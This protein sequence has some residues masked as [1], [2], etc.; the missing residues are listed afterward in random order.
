LRLDSPF[1][2]L[3][4]NGVKK[5]MREM[6]LIP[7]D[8]R[9]HLSTRRM[10]IGF[11][12]LYALIAVALIAGKVFQDLRISTIKQQIE[13]LEQ[14]Q[15]MI[16]DQRKMIDQ[17]RLKKS[18]VEN[19]LDFVKMIQHGGSAG[20]VFLVFDRVLQQQRNKVWLQAWQYTAAN[21]DV[22]RKD[23]QHANMSVIIR[24]QAIDHEALSSFVESLISQPEITDVQLKNTTKSGAE[25]STVMFEMEI[26]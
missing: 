17:L 15:G 18:A 23:D 3:I 8:Y 14:Q 10:L 25:N 19:Q 13:T 20:Q 22:A 1:Q 11:G 12:V 26:I 7:E 21:L 6:D 2:D 4:N 24:G 9:R 5:Q 16:V